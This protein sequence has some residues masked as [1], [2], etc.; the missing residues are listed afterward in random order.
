MVLN[1]VWLNGEHNIGQERGERGQDPIL[2]ITIGDLRGRHFES[3]F[4]MHC[5]YSGTSEIV[6]KTFSVR[7]T[8]YMIITKHRTLILYVILKYV[9]IFPMMY[10]DCFHHP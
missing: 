5:G 7:A 2:L 8:I 4:A 10:L 6:K 3:E 9:I 1:G